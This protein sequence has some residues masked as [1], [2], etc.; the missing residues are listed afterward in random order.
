M[1]IHIEIDIELTPEGGTG[2]GVKTAAFDPRSEH[3]DVVKMWIGICVAINEYMKA[4]GIEDF[5]CLN[6]L[7]RTDN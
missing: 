1:S 4:K 2:V 3:E 6:E 7:G 5:N